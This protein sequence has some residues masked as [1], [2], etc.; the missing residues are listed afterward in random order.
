[1]CSIKLKEDSDE[2]EILIILYLK[3][4]KSKD[5]EIHSRYRKAYYN[6]LDHIQRKIRNRVIPRD[7]LTDPAM[8]AICTLLNS[9]N[10][11]AYITTTGLDYTTFHELHSPFKELFEN[12]TQLHWRENNWKIVRKL[13][14]KKGRKRKFTSE[15]ALAFVLYHTRSRGAMWSMQL[16][17]GQTQSTTCTSMSRWMRFAGNI[18]LKLLKKNVHAK[19]STITSN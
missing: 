4:R 18:L 15:M 3:W 1:M 16:P 17:F 13:N 11:Q 9:R 7:A 6:Q 5:G 8:S 19:L 10:D 2:F 12:Y 14:P